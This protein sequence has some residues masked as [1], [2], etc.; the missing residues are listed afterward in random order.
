M[1]ESSATPAPSSLPAANRAG[2]PRRVAAE[3]TLPLSAD[4]LAELTPTMRSVVERMARAQHTPMWEQ[5][6]SLARQGYEIGSSVLEIPKP[7]LERVELLEIPARDGYAI[8]AKLYATS[9]DPLQPVLLF[10][11]GGGF[12]IGSVSTHD[13][14]CRELARQADCMVISVDYRLAPEHK[15]PTACN[16]AWDALQWLAAEGGSLG[17]DTSRIAVGGD[18]AGGTLA[19]VNAILA[20]DAGLPLALQLLI[21]P[22]CAGH[23][24][25]PSHARYS[26]GPILT[27]PMITWMFGNYTRT[28]ADRDDWRFAPLLAPDVRGVAPACIQLAQCDALVDEGMLYADKLRAAGVAVDVDIYQG[29]AHEFVK[30]GRALKEAKACHAKSAQALRAAFD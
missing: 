24:D 22:G 27:E 4:V 8:P 1:S 12:T 17:A 21:Y 9:F 7:A 16:D 13:T 25:T 15:F 14:L 10:T 5:P 19:A 18:S 26:Q 11:H 20:R 29:V 3:V 28:P 30:M 2:A 6:V 23:Q